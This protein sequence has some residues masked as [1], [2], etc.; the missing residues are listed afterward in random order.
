[1]Q[2]SA[3]TCIRSITQP[4]N[5]CY[6]RKPG[7]CTLQCSDRVRQLLCPRPKPELCKLTAKNWSGGRGQWDAGNPDRECFNWRKGKYARANCRFLH[8]F[9]CNVRSSWLS[10][11]HL[12]ASGWH[13]ED[14]RGRKC[15]GR[16]WGRRSYWR[17][18]SWQVQCW[19]PEMHSFSGNPSAANVL[20]P[21]HAFEGW[22]RC[23]FRCRL[24]LQN[25]VKHCWRASQYGTL[26]SE[27]VHTL[28]GIVR[29]QLGSWCAVGFWHEFGNCHGMRCLAAGPSLLSVL[30]KKIERAG[31]GL[32]QLHLCKALTLTP[33]S[34][35]SFSW[36]A[37]AEFGAHLKLGKLCWVWAKRLSALKGRV[38]KVEAP[39]HSALQ[40][41]HSN[42]PSSQTE[43]QS[44]W[45]ECRGSSEKGL[46]WVS[47]VWTKKY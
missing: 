29:E 9:L 45:I 7:W 36:K 44:L 34:P 18:P 47:S 22:R 15:R 41:K 31:V 37:G 10:C 4:T 35:H 21:T 17:K 11:R 3:W 28:Q 12:Q 8:S 24:A 19:W 43:S 38:W 23:G 40:R 13:K 32:E 6:S 1:M 39:A 33:V 25:C 42:T 46:L 16:K 30:G 2:W 14:N 20:A 5:F 27:C 26:W